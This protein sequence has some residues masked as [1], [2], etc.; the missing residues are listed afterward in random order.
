MQVELQSESQKKPKKFQRVSVGIFL[1][2]IL[3]Q[4]VTN[5]ADIVSQIFLKPVSFSPFS[6]LV[7]I[8]T[9]PP[10]EGLTRAK[11]SIP[12]DQQQLQICFICHRCRDLQQISPQC[13]TFQ[14]F[15]A[16][17]RTKTKLFNLACKSL[18]DLVPVNLLHSHLLLQLSSPP[19][20]TQTSS[21]PNA[22]N[23]IVFPSAC[24]W[25]YYTSD[26]YA[27]CLP[28]ITILTFILCLANIHPCFKLTQL[29]H[30][31]FQETFCESC[32]LGLH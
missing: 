21:Y 29:R 23:I 4:S 27:V 17:H 30:Y 14:G 12:P 32:C 9:T 2:S 11:C 3:S 25:R 7:F 28:E 1:D 13:K 5:L 10:L 8:L 18:Y 16:V 24:S 6:L 19:F 20:P 15:P 22:T 26:P 31:L